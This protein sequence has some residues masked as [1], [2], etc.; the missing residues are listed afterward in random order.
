VVSV[1]VALLQFAT[2]VASFCNNFGGYFEVFYC[3]IPILKLSRKIKKTY[4]TQCGLASQM[5]IISLLVENL[6]HLVANGQKHVQ[7][8]NVLHFPLTFIFHFNIRWCIHRRVTEGDVT[9]PNISDN[10]NNENFCNNE[11]VGRYHNVIK[12]Y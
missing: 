11:T 2:L 6:G 5:A 7:L 10:S 8:R 1:L 4:A 3:E 12:V 9:S